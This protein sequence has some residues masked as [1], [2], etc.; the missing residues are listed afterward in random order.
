MLSTARCRSFLGDAT[1]TDEEIDRIRDEMYA[2]A[3]TIVDVVI[4]ESKVK[5]ETRKG[6]EPLRRNL[7]LARSGDE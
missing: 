6:V 2:L 5:D 1:L 4:S 3:E 7:R